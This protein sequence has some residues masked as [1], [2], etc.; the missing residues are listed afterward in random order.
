MAVA[1]PSG[2][3]SA[4]SSLP[5]HPSATPHEAS[6]AEPARA[7]GDCGATACGGYGV[8]HAEPPRSFDRVTALEA[9]L[10]A[11]WGVQV[12]AEGEFYEVSLCALEF[13][14]DFAVALR[15]S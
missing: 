6:L 3:V 13:D 7:G 2:R 15:S 9:A 8:S 12:A 4:R 14:S 10:L 5:C 11:F 1:V